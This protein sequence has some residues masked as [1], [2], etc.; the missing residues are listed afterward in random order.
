MHVELGHA[1]MHVRHDFSPVLVAG[2]QSGGRCRTPIVVAT[3]CN[4]KAG[5][6]EAVIGNRIEK[7]GSERRC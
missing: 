5:D 6:I 4:A 3:G 1:D 2:M 7:R